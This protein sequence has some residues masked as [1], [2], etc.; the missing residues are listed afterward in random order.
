MTFMNIQGTLT[1][2]FLFM[3]IDMRYIYEKLFCMKIKKILMMISFECFLKL[4]LV[5]CTVEL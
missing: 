3:S 4:M 2:M 5:D 1:S